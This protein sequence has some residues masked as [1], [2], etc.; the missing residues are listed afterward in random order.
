MRKKITPHDALSGESPLVLTATFTPVAKLD[1][2]QPAGFPE[3]GHVI[4]KAP[5]ADGRVEHVCIVDSAA[6]MA[7]HLESVCVRGAHDL[8]LVDD[9]QGM[10]YLRCVTGPLGDDGKLTEREVVVTS[11]TEGHRIASSYFLDG[12]RLTGDTPASPRVKAL[13]DVAKKLKDGAKNLEDQAEKKEKEKA[14]K[15]K[16][17]EAKRIEQEAIFQ[18]A[19]IREFG[20]V[21]A[22]NK[23]AAHAPPEKWWEVFKT[24]FKYDPSSLV[25]GVLFPQWQIKIPRVLTAHLEAFGASRVDRSGVK[26]DRLGKT[27]SGQPIFAVDDATAREIRATFILDLALVRSFGRN[28][29]TPG[30]AQR[31]LTEAQKEFLVALALWKVQRLLAAPFRFRSG[32]HLRFASLKQG[33]SDVDLAALAVDIK[34]ALGKAQFSTPAVTDVYWP[35][36]ELYR[37]AE[38]DG[39]AESGGGGADDGADAEDAGGG[40]DGD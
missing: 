32:C 1:R 13:K 5:R 16:S 21:L 31:G 23:R 39:D 10:P 17:D 19:L 40:E 8:D 2:F 38:P 20:I 27:T 30:D 7:N 25:H 37:D 29:A 22:D 12:E 11:L 26:F 33:E 3:V 14:A 36:D 24:I 28:G 15:D 34:A 18:S 6:S 4:Y 9:L 35:R